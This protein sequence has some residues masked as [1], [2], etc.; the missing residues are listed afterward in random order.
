MGGC[1]VR[2]YRYGWAMLALAALG[3]LLYFVATHAQV[4][5]TFLH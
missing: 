2:L 5:Q 3:V 4:I 1:L